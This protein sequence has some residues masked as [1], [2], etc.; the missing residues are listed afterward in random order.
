MNISLKNHNRCRPWRVRIACL[1]WLTQCTDLAYA[2]QLSDL[3]TGQ[4]PAEKSAGQDKVISVDHSK[5]NDKKIEKRLQE[6]FS[7]LDELKDIKATVSNGVV[8]LQGEVGSTSAEEKAIQF[9][10]QIENVVEVKNKLTISHSLTKRSQN[11][12]QKIR[13][14]GE[15]FIAGLPLVLV[16]ILLVFLF[17]MLGRWCSQR[18]G[19]F[20]RIS[21]N[22]FIA[23]LLGKLTHLV[24]F[25]IGV[26]TALTLLDATALIRTLLG[27]AGIFG[28]A[29]GFAVRDTVENFITSL[30]LSIRNPFEV[31]DYVNIE[32]HEGNVARLTS[33]ATIL[34]SPDGNHIRI[35]NSTVFKAVIINY[36]RKPERRFQFDI[37]IDSNQDL[38]I[39]QGLA[40]ETMTAVPGVLA[41][42]KPM[43]VIEQ[44]G[45]YNVLIRIYGW[46]DQSDCAYLK[47]RGEAIRHVKQAF[48]DANIIMPEP[49]YN[50]RIARKPRQTPEERK[51]K[52]LLPKRESIPETVKRQT[53]EAKDV[54]VDRTAEK[55]IEKENMQDNNENLLNPDAPVEM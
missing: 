32:G 12:V 51:E 7:E 27:V 20:R 53:E 37:G 23:D 40:L 34:I 5:Q 18:Q 45:D 25:V 30:L 11:A 49:I 9:A 36:T 21:T 6:I 55:Q 39:A 29:I 43:T 33:R 15:K 48:D 16:A 28:L 26:I 19:F 42:P 24:F 4:S 1:I 38:L 41:D 14:L 47:V 52:S 8:S 35:P 3:L 13:L 31:N 44:L 10:K 22:Y 54:T 17:W 50:L 2:Q 46:V